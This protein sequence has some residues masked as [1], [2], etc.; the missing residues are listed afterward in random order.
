MYTLVQNLMIEQTQLEA[1]GLHST[2]LD[3]YSHLS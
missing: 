2:T 3:L 1:E